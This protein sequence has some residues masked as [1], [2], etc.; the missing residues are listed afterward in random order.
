VQPI[1]G[2]IDPLDIFS[3]MNHT[4]DVFDSLDVLWIEKP[5][6]SGFEKQPQSF[7]PEALDQS[8]SALRLM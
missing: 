6:L 5:A 8:C 7:M 2:Y 3:R 1:A 4:K